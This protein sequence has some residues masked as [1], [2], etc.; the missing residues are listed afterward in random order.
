MRQILVDLAKC[1]GCR[2]CEKACSN[3]HSATTTGDSKPISRVKVLFTKSENGKKGSPYPMRCHQCEFPKCA[4]ACMSGALIKTKDG[5]VIHEDERCVGCW[6]CVMTCPYGAVF[7]DVQRKVV[8]KC[9]TCLTEEIPACV[10]VCKFD[11]MRIE[12]SE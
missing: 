5:I 9:D 2:Q 3:A 4:E 11:A 1:K 7:R 10:A 12:E 8:V 6:M